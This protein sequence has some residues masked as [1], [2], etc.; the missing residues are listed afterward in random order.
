MKKFLG[1]VVLGLSLIIPSQADDIRDFQ[2]EGMSIGDSLL[3]YFSKKEIEANLSGAQYPNNEFIIR[4]FRKLPIFTIYEGV[5]IAH[6]A[7]DK[8]YKIYDIGGS[9]YYEKNFKN[10][11]K[12]M[13][14]IEKELDQIFENPTVRSGTVKHEYDKTGKSIQTITEY[15][16]ESGHNAQIVC[17]NWSDELEK[18]GHTDELNISIGLKEYADF[19]KY[20]A[21]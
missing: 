21:Y 2:I 4:Y 15:L 7:S 8:D 13:N 3:D 9:I 14:E 6:K 11:H 18:Q 16:F 10:C 1:I 20:R 19:V 12:K 17:I 5:T